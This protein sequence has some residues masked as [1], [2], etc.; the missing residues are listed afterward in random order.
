MKSTSRLRLGNRFRSG[1]S[2]VWEKYM[3]HMVLVFVIFFSD[4]FIV[5]FPIAWWCF[6]M[7]TLKLYVRNKKK[8][9]KTLV[10]SS[11]LTLHDCAESRSRC[12]TDW[13]FVVNPQSIPFT[14][15]T[16][17]PR[18]PIVLLLTLTIL[19]LS[20]N[21]MILFSMDMK[22]HR[23]VVVILVQVSSSLYCT[24]SC[25]YQIHKGI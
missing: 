4:L 5:C 12:K 1:W 7:T 21:M 24:Y 22:L 18:F 13:K 6:R 17:F 20:K 19:G 3:W 25:L 11:G 10:I 9:N 2:Q 16:G 14:S 23:I 15:L 8:Q